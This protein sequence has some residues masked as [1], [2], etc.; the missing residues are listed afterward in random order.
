MAYGLSNYGKEEVFDTYFKGDETPPSSFDIVLYNDSTDTLTDS[1]TSDTAITSEP[2][3]ASYAAQSVNLDG[4]DMS[5]AQSG[6]YY[7]ITMKDVTFDV[8][9]ST[10]TVDS[11]AVLDGSNVFGRGALD[12]S[13]DLSNEN[14]SITYQDIAVRLD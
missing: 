14:G 8:S 10:E 3:G 12:T 7:V 13:R 9:D 11:F 6:D 5:G 2:T 4:T 1:D